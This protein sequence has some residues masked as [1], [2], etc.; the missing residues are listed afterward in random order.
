MIVQL[1]N[2][3]LYTTFDANSFNEF[4]SN[5]QDM[6]PSMVEYY[7]NDLSSDNLHDNS[8]YINKTNIQQ[9]VFIDEFL[10]HLDYN[11]DI[12]LEFVEKTSEYD[13]ASFF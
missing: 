10:V 12:Y 6:A 4:E 13:T 5:V 9:T 8:V 11:D 2:N 1:D 7:L 3:L